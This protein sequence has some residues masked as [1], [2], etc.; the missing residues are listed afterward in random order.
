MKIEFKLEFDTEKKEDLE[1]IEEI[2]LLLQEL[3][4][5]LE[6]EKDDR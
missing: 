5:A 3:K 6:G 2:V 4:T 1:R